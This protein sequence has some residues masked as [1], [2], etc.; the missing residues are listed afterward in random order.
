MGVLK[1]FVYVAVCP[2]SLGTKIYPFVRE[3]RPD[4]SFSTGK[5]KMPYGQRGKSQENWQS[6]GLQLRCTA[7]KTDET[8]LGLLPSPHSMRILI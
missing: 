8:S 5:C 3:M 1:M 2:N 6:L 4:W 7:R